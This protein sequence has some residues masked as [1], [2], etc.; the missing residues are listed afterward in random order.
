MGS[1]LRWGVSC[2]YK[3]KP[4]RPKAVK[5]N[6]T[7]TPLVAPELLLL[8]VGVPVGPE[9]DE[10]KVTPCGK[11]GDVQGRHPQDVDLPRSDT[12]IAA[13]IDC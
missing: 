6:T 3:T 1:V 5:A 13:A 9:P 2:F 7:L 11:L 8:E 4:M 10:L 12:E